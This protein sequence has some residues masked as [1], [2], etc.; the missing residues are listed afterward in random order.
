M[1]NIF[2]AETDTHFSQIRELTNEF[3]EWDREQTTQLG[4]D[5]IK[6]VDF[7]YGT[8]DDTLPGIYAPPKGCFLLASDLGKAAGMVAF[9]EFSSNICEMTRM[10]VR[11]EFRGKQLAQG[12]IK[13]LIT[14]ARESNY[15]IMRLET[16]TFM[17]SAITVYSS[18]GFK[19][20][21]PYYRIPEEFL[22]ITVFME[23]DISSLG[24]VP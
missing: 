18:F 21:S 1:I 20:C 5:P 15:D 4:L 6:V 16:T 14:R 7:Y 2:Q 13:M 24:K 9:K 22:D 11:P 23:L 8:R 17:Q 3:R 12:L 10:Y 19:T